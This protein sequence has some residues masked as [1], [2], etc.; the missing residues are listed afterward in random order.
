MGTGAV[1][2]VNVNNLAS[3]SQT[4]IELRGKIKPR[5]DLSNHRPADSSQNREVRSRILVQVLMLPWE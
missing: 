3:A 1:S 5:P 4:S 2:T